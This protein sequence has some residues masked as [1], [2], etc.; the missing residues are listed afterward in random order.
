MIINIQLYKKSCARVI[1]L[2]LMKDID[3]SVTPLDAARVNRTI[4]RK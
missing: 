1:C 3:R 2:I 4:L